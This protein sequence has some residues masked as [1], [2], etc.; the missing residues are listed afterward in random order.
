MMH[1]GGLC[2][3]SATACVSSR[4]RRREPSVGPPRSGRK[5]VST[6]PVRFRRCEFVFTGLQGPMRGSA[7]LLMRTARAAPPT[8]KREGDPG[9]KPDATIVDEALDPAYDKAVEDVPGVRAASK[10]PRLGQRAAPVRNIGPA[11]VFD[12]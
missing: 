3:L 8:A 5:W 6:V 10:T 4:A 12:G 9:V 7:S 1:R 11:P 2:T